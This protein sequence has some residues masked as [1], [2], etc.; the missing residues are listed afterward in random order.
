MRRTFV[1]LTAVLVVVIAASTRVLTHE[2]PRSV[3]VNMFVHAEKD[4]L[5]VLIRVPLAA[6]RD[7]DFPQRDGFLDIPKS[8][9]LLLDAVAQWILP[10]LKLLE[11]GRILS[12]PTI[13]DARISLP[14]DRSFTSLDEARAH[15]DAASLPETVRLPREQALV[16]VRL[17]YPIESGAA[18]FSIEPGFQRLGIDVLTVVRFVKDGSTRAFEFSGNP[19]VVRLDPRWHQAAAQFVTLG[20]LHILDGADH[21]LFLACLVIPLRRLRALVVVVSAF[22]LAHSI[23]LIGIALG[24]APS[25]L[26]FPPAIEVLIAASI[27]FMA[28]ENIVAMPSLNRRCAMAFGFGLVHGFGFSFALRE[29]LQFAGT[30]LLASLV[31]FNVGV[32]LGQLLL[33]IGLVPVLQLMFRFVVTE[34]MGTIVLSA[35]VCHTA[36]HWM[37]ERWATL[38]AYEGSPTDNISLIVAVRMALLTV[39]TL[40]LIWFTRW[41][42]AKRRSAEAALDE[43]SDARPA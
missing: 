35:L 34:R 14:S 30:H 11:G 8:E 36:W 15:F 38:R 31:S 6:M 26:W 21:L 32:E 25:G 43:S 16:D 42:A 20:F 27:V 5:E 23:T 22:T 4:R 19:G 37:T 3:T 7:I 12:A 13:A 40:G 17:A 24:L 2:I 18:R 1:V 28:I 33:L 29:T 9:P 39:V 10:D 41:S